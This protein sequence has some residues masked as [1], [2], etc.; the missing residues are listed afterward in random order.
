[1]DI[2]VNLLKA[3]QANKSK[4]F[5]WGLWFNVHSVGSFFPN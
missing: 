4:L 1:M 5:A 2:Q 3:P